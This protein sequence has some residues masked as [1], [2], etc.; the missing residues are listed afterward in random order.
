MY[1]ILESIVVSQQLPTSVAQPVA[2]NLVR[3]LTGEAS[4]DQGAL[5]LRKLISQLHQRR[6]KAVQDACQTVI[7]ED[8]QRRDAV[9]GLV[10]SLAVVS[11]PSAVC[12]STPF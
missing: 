2:S 8:E 6:P 3:R 12:A 1:P 9:E 4:E 10:T 5:E 11:I 7:R